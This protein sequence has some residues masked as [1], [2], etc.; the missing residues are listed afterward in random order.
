MYVREPHPQ[1][2]GFRQYRKHGSYEHKMEYARLLAEKHGLTIPVLVDGLDEKVHQ[3]L[4]NLPNL[5]YVVNKQ[6]RVEYK[7]TWTDAD[8]I[9]EV[10]AEMVTAEDP[11]RPVSKTMDSSQVP[12]RVPVEV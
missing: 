4:G 7:C 6:G 12:G 5:V 10:L 1:E 2:R 3:L 9:D 11:S 8:A